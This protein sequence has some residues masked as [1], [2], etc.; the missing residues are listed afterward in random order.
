MPLDRIKKKIAYLVLAH[1]HPLQLSRMV[2]RLDCEAVEF[3]IHIDKKSHITPF[4]T[5]LEAY[6]RVTFLEKRYAVYWKG[7]SQILATMAL[8]KAA[9]ASRAE[10]Y[11]LLSGSDY[12][13]KPNNE[14]LRFLEGNNTQY[15][16]FFSLHDFPG[17]LK[18]VRYYY[19]DSLLTNPR[20]GFRP[21][22]WR[23]IK[24]I[25]KGILNRLPPRKLPSGIQQPYGGSQW[26]MLT[27]D[28]AAYCLDF[29][30]KN[31]GFRRFYRF[32]DS[33]DE[34]V[35]Q[36]II[37]NSPFANSVRNYL[38]Y[39]NNRK[40]VVAEVLGKPLG[41]CPYNYR[42]IDWHSPQ[43]GFPATLNEE[44]FE[45]MVESG[46]LLARKLDPEKS[47]SLLNRID[48]ELLAVY[49]SSRL[50]D[51]TGRSLAKCDPADQIPQH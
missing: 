8:L 12:P 43:R 22:K 3:F 21:V 10:Y 49:P 51:Q 40:Q 39:R 50:A 28:C 30:E 20:E 27:H 4:K 37:L 1:H 19:W 2:A 25:Q 34:M 17:W 18:K 48:R 23:Y 33:P 24:Y 7:F 47:R 35:F 44:N 13:L 32:T 31:P 41:F 14:I 45:E 9:L 5:A 42:Y 6:D 46:A 15:L 26:W 29:L 36:T 11:I 16:H 38:Q